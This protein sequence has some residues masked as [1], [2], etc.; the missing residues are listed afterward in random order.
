MRSESGEHCACRRGVRAAALYKSK[1]VRRT[2]QRQRATYVLPKVHQIPNDD[3]VSGGWDLQRPPVARGSNPSARP[4]AAAAPARARGTRPR[5]TSS[6][7]AARA[8]SAVLAR[9]PWS[10]AAAGRTRSPRRSPPAGPA[11]LA[12]M[13]LRCLHALGCPRRVR[14]RMGVGEASLRRR[15]GGARVRISRRSRRARG[16]FGG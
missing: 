15:R 13:R 9:L 6:P 11:A 7:R 4:R 10:E 14:A 8:A 16:L 5:R 2:T 12:R 3:K 1:Y